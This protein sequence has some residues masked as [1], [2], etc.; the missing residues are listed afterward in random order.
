MSMWRPS[1]WRR[2]A[3]RRSRR[4][5]RPPPAS[6]SAA[7]PPAEAAPSPRHPGR[8]R[9]SATHRW[10]ASPLSGRAAHPRRRRRPAAPPSTPRTFGR[11]RTP[12]SSTWRSTLPPKGRDVN[13]WRRRYR[14][15][16]VG[17]VGWRERATKAV[18]LNTP[19]A[20]E[21]RERMRMRWVAWARATW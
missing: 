8:T 13:G 4:P 14:R 11:W 6:R 21:R 5:Y 2:A 15:E 10:R 3:C 18:I 20:I 9:T 12:W 19:L 17:E 7:S 1:G 16:K